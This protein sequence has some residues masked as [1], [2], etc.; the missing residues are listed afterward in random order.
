MKRI[1]STTALAFGLTLA[2]RVF[3]IWMAQS[4]L[5]FHC[6]GIAMTFTGGNQPGGIAAATSLLLQYRAD[7]SNIFVRYQI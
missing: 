1:L 4:G 7:E 5:V 6:N 2:G 3:R